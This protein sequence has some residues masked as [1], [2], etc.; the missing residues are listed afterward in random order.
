MPRL[1]TGKEAAEAINARTAAMAETLTSRGVVP[2][3][4]IVRVGERPDDV[5]YES[6]AIKRCGKVGIQ[7]KSVVLP[8]DVDSGSFYDA[9]DACSRDGSIHGMLLL[10]PFPAGVRDEKVRAMLAAEKDVD[11]C[12]EGSLAGVFSGSGRGYPPCTAQAIMEIIDYYGIDCTGKHCVVIGR[13]LVVGRPAAMML[14]HR[15][16]TVTIC[17]SHSDG[18]SRIVREAD[19]VVTATGQTECFGKEYFRTGQVVIDAGIGWSEEKKKLC[20]DVLFEE[21]ESIVSAITPVP[22]GVG[23]VTTSVLA[24][25]VAMA[26]ERSMRCGQEG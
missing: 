1:L 20:G 7:V 11:G 24:E 12:T 15:N 19:I 22:G 8:T 3:L 16:A 10:R 21:A 23:A 4:C 13:S 5:A 18:L 9:V 17:H 6:G 2:A 26:A 14:M 25:H